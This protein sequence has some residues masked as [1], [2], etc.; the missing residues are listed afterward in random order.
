MIT[1]NTVNFVGRFNKAQLTVDSVKTGETLEVGGLVHGKGINPSNFTANMILS[2]HL[3]QGGKLGGPGNY[4]TAGRIGTELSPENMTE[5]YGIFTLGQIVTGQIII[6]SQ[7]VGTDSKGVSLPPD[8]TIVSPW[9]TSGNQWLINNAVDTTGGFTLKAPQLSV[10][11][12][13]LVGATANNDYLEVQPNLA[14][15]FNMARS[16]MSYATGSAAD[17]LMLS[18]AFGALLSSPGGIHPSIAQMM[19][20]YISS[21]DN[22]GKAINFTQLQTNDIRLLDLLKAWAASPAGKDYTFISAL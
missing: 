5:T 3:N 9:G 19:S 17:A 10:T 21:T 12:N 13:F 1:S 20:Y 8:T 11:N 22:T 7:I 14:A 2:Q 4:S 15:Q 18:Q 16:T 6:G